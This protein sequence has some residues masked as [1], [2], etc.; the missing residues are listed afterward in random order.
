VLAW[1]LF[2]EQRMNAVKLAS[3]DVGLVLRVRA[4]LEDGVVPREEVTAAV[5]ELMVREKGALV[6]RRAQELRAEA[7]KAAMSG[8][9]AHQA[10]TAIVDMMKC[11]ATASPTVAVVAAGGGL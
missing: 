6:R 2:A 4:R 8:G 5:R 11:A 7:H 3:E 10:L 9:P 1:P